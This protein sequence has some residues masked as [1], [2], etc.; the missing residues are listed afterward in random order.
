VKNG[1]LGC[2]SIKKFYLAVTDFYYLTPNRGVVLLGISDSSHAIVS[3]VKMPWLMLGLIYA[4]LFFVLQ[5]IHG[6]STV[7]RHFCCKITQ[8]CITRC[9]TLSLGLP[10]ICNAVQHS[11]N[12]RNSLVLNYKSAALPAELCRQNAAHPTARRY[13]EQ[14]ANARSVNAS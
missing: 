2:I 6:P 12:V 13:F 14:V 11:E 9:K 8:F 3:D 10:M 5:N 1:C 4:A 7:P